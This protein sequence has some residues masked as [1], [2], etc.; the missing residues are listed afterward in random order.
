MYFASFEVLLELHY[1]MFDTIMRGAK[2]SENGG[3]KS[4]RR[5]WVEEISTPVALR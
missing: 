1:T 4:R 2:Q 3:G 5:P